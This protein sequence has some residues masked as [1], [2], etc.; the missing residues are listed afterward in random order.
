L[1]KY[2]PQILKYIIKEGGYFPKKIYNVDETGL[3]LK[4]MSSRTYIS[5][6]DMTAPGF[7]AAKDHL[8]LMLGSNAEGDVNLMP[9]VVY[10]EFKGS[11]GLFQA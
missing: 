8:S 10:H 1:A 3:N 2:Y 6:E 9:L 4:R 5:K 7:K 11:D